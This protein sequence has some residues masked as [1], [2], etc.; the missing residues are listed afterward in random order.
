MTRGGRLKTREQPE[1]R[2]IATGESAPREGLIRFVLGPDGQVAPDLAERL[3]GRGAWVTARRDALEKAVRRGLFSRA[4]KTRA[5]AAPDLPERVEALLAARL[6]ELIALCRKAGLA[7][8]G[9]EKV[10]ARLKKGPVAALIEARDGSEQGR[11]K[12]RPLAGKAPIVD[13]LSSR[14]L[15]LAF[16]RE[17]VIHAALDEGGLAQSVLR[18]S[19]R[20]SGFRTCDDAQDMTTPA[21]GGKKDG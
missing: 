14:E 17:F 18:E 13:C 2:C 19:L 1:R 4:F 9:F 3:P 20:L 12:L 6:T 11:A 5:A 8:T 21:Q 15:G 16:G 7:V 10:K